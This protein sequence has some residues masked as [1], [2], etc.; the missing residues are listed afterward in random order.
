MLFQKRSWSERDW[1]FGGNYFSRF[2]SFGLQMFWSL[3]YLQLVLWIIKKLEVEDKER[4]E[5]NFLL[6][7]KILSLLI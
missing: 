7:I 3:I 2:F 4:D 6:E 5:R 1:N